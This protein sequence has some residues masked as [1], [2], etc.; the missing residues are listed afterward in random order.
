MFPDGSKAHSTPVRFF[1]LASLLLAA[2]S[3]MAF[4][5]GLPGD[6]LFDDIPN[7]VNNR[8]IHLTELTPSAIVE[9]LATPQISGNLRVLPTLTFA[10]DYWRAGG[11]ADPATFKTTNIVIHVFTT[12]ALAWFFRSLPPLAG[13]SSRRVAP[14]AVALSVAWAV[15]PLQVSAVLYAVQ[16][17]QTMGTLFLVLALCTY[18]QARAAQIRGQSGRTSLMVT[19]LLWA[20]AMGCKEDSALLP[21]YA[22]AMEL[23]VLRFAAAD[24]SVARLWRSGYLI[25]VLAAAVAY[26]VWLYNVWQPAAYP[27]RDF[28]SLERLLTQ[29]RVLCMYLWQIVVPLP[30][31]M[32]F[33]YDWVQP[34]RRLLHPWTTLPAFALILALVAT[35][36]RLRVRQPL[37]AL[38]VFLFF[39]AHFIASN[40]IGLE[41]AYEH[42]NHF[43][44]IGAVLAIG[45]ALAHLASRLPIRT[46]VQTGLC[47]ALLLAL[48]ATTAVRAHSWRNALSLAQASAF[49]APDSPRAWIDLCDTYFMVGGGVT[50]RN[51]NLNLAIS[52][53]ASGADA[54]PDSLNNLALLVALKSLRGDVTPQDWQR[55]Q[56]RLRVVPMTADNTRAPLILVHYA[57]LGVPVDSA[58]M[59]SALATLDRRTTLGPRTLIFIGDALLNALDDP[60]HAVPY[61][62][63]AIAV[64]P[65]DSPFAWQLAAALRDR[66]HP[67]LAGNVEQ[68]AAAR[69]QAAPGSH[70]ESRP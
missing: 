69:H 20:L 40:A 7:I 70:P 30:Q 56:Q 16:R 42:R 63:K 36:W 29:P 4:L 34:S 32:P 46:A 35:A 45:S 27:G 67:E 1:L 13:V 65:P 57:T 59:R 25:V 58:Q 24:A 14:I 39:S 11:S 23:T 9:V 44:L 28:N 52:A 22:L 61:Y 17:L 55:L 51:P 10:L 12:F 5:P 50:E 33:H 49:A 60:E 47:A 43:A 66:D 2:L 37:F 3:G 26:V 18:L 54:A 62:L 68:A 41:L 19:V 21:V 8:S 15:H 48:G 53:C 6:F 31:H 64:L 38:G